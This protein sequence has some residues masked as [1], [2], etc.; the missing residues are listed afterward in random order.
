[1]AVIATL[2]SPPGLGFSS[3]PISECLGLV[4]GCLTP[5]RTLR[6]IAVVC[7][8]AGLPYISDSCRA[9]G[10]FKAACVTSRHV[11]LSSIQGRLPCQRYK[12]YKVRIKVVPTMR[13]MSL[14]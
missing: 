6:M 4:I 5:A 9:D 8:T 1:M 2:F 7:P 11:W 3:S 10:W 12:F 13:S 14:R